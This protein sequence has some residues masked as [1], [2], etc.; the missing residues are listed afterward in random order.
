MIGYG[1]MGKTI[2]EVAA[3]RKHRIVARLTSNANAQDWEK[4]RMANVCIEF[5]RPDAAPTN[6]KRCLEM[7]LPVVTG[8]TGWYERMDEVV[9]WCKSGD[10][11][12]FWA[13]NFSIGVNLF[14][15][16]N[17]KLAE[18]MA[19]HPGY[20][21][22]ITEIHHTQKLDAPSGTAITTA[23]QI[24][25]RHPGYDRWRLASEGD[26]PATL[27]IDAIREEDV[28]GTHIV[29]YDSEV[30]RIELKHEA[31]SRRGFALGAVLAAEWLLDK[32][33]LFTMEDMLS[34]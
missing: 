26:A 21:A 9:T 23:E 7:G 11:S 20:K 16:A 32:K 4:L 5:T 34:M 31:K 2:E 18:L 33:G 1:K 30:D 15:Q 19:L 28:K 29:S 25:Q 14:W 3:E 6:F 27:L 8:T 10:C 13:S 12:F 24:I 17:K 22:G